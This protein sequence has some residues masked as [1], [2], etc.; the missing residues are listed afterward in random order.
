MTGDNL[1]FKISC[2]LLA[3][4]EQELRTAGNPLAKEINQFLQGIL[5]EQEAK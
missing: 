4:A 2:I 1:Q 3:Q 5:K